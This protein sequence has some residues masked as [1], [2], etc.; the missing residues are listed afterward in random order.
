MKGKLQETPDQLGAHY[1][2]HGG[3]GS[4]PLCNQASE[5]LEKNFQ[6]Q[7]ALI[8]QR[9]RVAEMCEDPKLGGKKLCNRA[10]G[11]SRCARKKDAGKCTPEDLAACARKNKAALPGWGKARLVATA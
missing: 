1:C 7:R 6:E 10:E 4:Q 2:K 9:Q 5:L 3:E 8:T 11:T